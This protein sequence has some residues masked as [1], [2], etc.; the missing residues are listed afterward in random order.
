VCHALTEKQGKH[1]DAVLTN[2][3]CSD[4]LLSDILACCRWMQHFAVALQC[5]NPLFNDL[6]QLGEAAGFV[7]TVTARADNPG[8]LT[9]KTLV[10]I[11]PS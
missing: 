1:L 3:V 4:H 9:D 10:L 5:L 6:A 7:V 2:S 8:A 11:R